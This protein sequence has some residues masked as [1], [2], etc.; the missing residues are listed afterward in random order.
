M[1]HKASTSREEENGPLEMVVFYHILGFIRT[2]VAL[3][4]L[5]HIDTGLLQVSEIPPSLHYVPKR[6]ALLSPF[7]R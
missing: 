6:K 4:G 3:L 1:L 2:V 7:C 5:S